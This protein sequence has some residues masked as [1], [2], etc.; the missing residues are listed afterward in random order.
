LPFFLIDSHPAF[1]SF[2][3]VTK[4]R[5]QIRC[6]K[7]AVK[8]QKTRRGIFCGFALLRY[9]SVL[10]SALCGKE[11]FEV[12]CGLCEPSVFSAVKAFLTGQQPLAQSPII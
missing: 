8:Q 12:L 3:A 2:L 9:S 1:S 6:E 10:A 7:A 5:W 4:S 11:S